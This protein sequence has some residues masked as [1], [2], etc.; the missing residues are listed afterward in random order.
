MG[1]QG[2]WLPWAVLAA[3]FSFRLLR[4]VGALAPYFGC[5]QADAWRAAQGFL[6]A[7]MYA[8]PFNFIGRAPEGKLGEHD[9]SVEPVDDLPGSSRCHAERC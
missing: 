5:L 4:P 7:E 3:G 9:S 2:R 6:Y 1:T 8:V